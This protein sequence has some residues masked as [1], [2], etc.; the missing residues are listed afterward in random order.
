MHIIYKRKDAVD[1]WIVE[2]KACCCFTEYFNSSVRYIY[3]DA[4]TENHN[5]AIRCDMF[6]D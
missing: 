4:G 1:F 5:I 3:D 6:L 2:T